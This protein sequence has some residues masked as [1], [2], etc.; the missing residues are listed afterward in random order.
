MSE[1]DRIH[2]NV[3][4]TTK[5]NIDKHDYTSDMLRTVFLPQCLAVDL[6]YHLFDVY[7]G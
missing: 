7:I 3:Y 5:N 2:R 4:L 6:V 1:F